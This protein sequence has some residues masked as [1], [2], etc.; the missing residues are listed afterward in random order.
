MYDELRAGDDALADWATNNADFFRPLDQGT[1]H[2][3]GEISAW[4]DNR[5]FKPAALNN[6]SRDNADFLL[7]TYAREHQC[8]VVTH[9]RSRPNAHGRVMIPDV[10]HAMNANTT[11]P[12]KMLRQTGA[13]FDLCAN[14]P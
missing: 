7:I 9:E 8:T 6:F 11:D 3:F 2:H 5:N 13:I 1:T 10:C 14:T 12:F 4:A